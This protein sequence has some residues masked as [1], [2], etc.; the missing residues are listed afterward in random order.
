MRLFTTEPAMLETGSAYLR[1]VGPAYGFFGVGLALYFASQGAGR[2][3]WPLLAGFVRLVLAAAGGW[4]VTRWLGGGPNAVFAA[5]AVALVVMG[6][7]V[8][9][10]IKAGA[11][12]SRRGGDPMTV[13]QIF[14]LQ[15][16]LSLLVGSLLAH[17]YVWPRLAALPTRR[18][19]AP[20][21]FVHATRYVGLVFLVPTVVPPGVPAAFAV[22][23]AYGDLLAAL[24]ALLALVAL[25]RDWPGAIG[26]RLGS[27]TS[28]ER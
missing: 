11:W 4:I 28:W 23:A 2:L 15:F 9:L 13:Q 27:S 26:A 14:G 24:L 5:I 17:W 12:R 7:M 21:L 6:V 20:L 16:A 22:P 25:R 19:V 10:P 18:A 3:A 1:I 8:A